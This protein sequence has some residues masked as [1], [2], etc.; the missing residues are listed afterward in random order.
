MT[1]PD[2]HVSFYQKLTVYLK[3]RRTQDFK[4]LLGF[5]DVGSTYCLGDLWLDEATFIV[6]L[7]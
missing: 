6:N 7:R 2:H 4:H 5:N 3:N 1:I